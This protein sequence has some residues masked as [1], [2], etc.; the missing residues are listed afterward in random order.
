MAPLRAVTVVNLAPNRTFM[1][2][3]IGKML[4]CCLVAGNVSSLIFTLELELEP[5]LV[6]RRVCFVEYI[7]HRESS[8]GT[9]DSP[10]QIYL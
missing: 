3:F 2:R 1:D 8:L 5:L 10:C 7:L 6:H 4:S 9:T